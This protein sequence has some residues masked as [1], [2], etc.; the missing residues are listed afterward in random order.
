MAALISREII[1]DRALGALMGA[2]IGDALA[3]GPHWYYDLKQLRQDYGEWISDYT[4]PKAG[5]YHEGLKAGDLSQ[6][7]YILKLTVK[8]LIETQG[9]YQEASFCDMLDQ[10]L[11]PLLDGTPISGPGGY[12]SQSI[13]HVYE[14]RVKQGKT[15][16]EGVAGYSDTTESAER[17]LVYAIRYA[18]QP[19]KLAE[20]VISNTQLI[21]NDC[22]VQAMTLAYG[23]LLGYLVEGNTFDEDISMALLARVKE[24]TLPFHVVT[25]GNLQAPKP[26]QPAPS[27][28]GLFPSPD[29]LLTPSTIA[30]AAK[31]PS[32]Q[33]EPAW[34]AS[35]VYGLPCAI[36]HQLPT[37]Y[38][39]SS[40]FSN[41]F[42]SAVLHA[43]NGGGQNQAR[44][45]L[46]GALVGAQVGFQQIP[47]RFVDGLTNGQELVLLCQQLVEFMF[48][49]E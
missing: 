43:V 3:L 18:L 41:D 33:I 44:A 6:A 31:D 2:F 7:G 17:I 13:R 22:M 26:G 35:L 37:A 21:Q 48:V 24:G 16:Q 23:A 27:N 9:E 11:F 34:K 42:E 32:I 10:E 47:K 36:Y 12:T 40:R 1:K 49:S 28:H 19:K 4:E 15:W 29:A 30:R 46:T 38:Y 14:Q 5:R 45:I 8:N 25:S 20:V 39:L